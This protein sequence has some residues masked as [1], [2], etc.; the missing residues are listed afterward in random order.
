MENV[1]GKVLKELGG[2]C[3]NFRYEIKKKIFYS[4]TRVFDNVLA[5]NLRPEKPEVAGSEREKEPTHLY[6]AE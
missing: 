5:L 4:G 3:I 1:R 2:K 6:P